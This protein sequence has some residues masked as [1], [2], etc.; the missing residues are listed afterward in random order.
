MKRFLVLSVCAGLALAGS[1]FAGDMTSGL[2]I[3][4]GQNGLAG[5]MLERADNGPQEDGVLKLQV[6]LNQAQMLKGYG[7]VL[8]YDQAR[9]EFIEAKEVEGN[10]L[11]T[12][13]GQQVLFLSSNKT[14]GQVAVG[15]MKV[16]G[17]S[18]QGDGQLVEIT[19]KTIETPL[20]TD[21]QIA[22]GV[23]VDLE[24]NI[25]VVQNIEIGNL[26]PTPD[27]YGL[28]QNMPNPFNPSTTIGYQLPE[29]GHV[30]LVVYNLLGQEVRKLVDESMDAGYYSLVWD[31]MD[32][33]GR[34]VASGIYMYRMQASTFSETRRMMLLK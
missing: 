9:Y 3:T 25:D 29:A 6:T 13:S 30:S 28:N 24:G 31:G 2:E 16:D 17:E 7:F 34:Q 5:L 19:F 12:G 4:G 22:E 26:K 20:P 27:I 8:H 23:L 21:F 15:A 11:D 33:L 10:I 32:D 1:S 14:P 18:V